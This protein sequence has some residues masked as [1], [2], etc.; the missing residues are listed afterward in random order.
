MSVLRDLKPY[1]NGPDIFQSERGFL[2]DQ[3]SWFQG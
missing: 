1:P 2:P 3:F